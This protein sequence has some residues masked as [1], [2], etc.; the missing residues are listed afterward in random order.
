VFTLPPPPTVPTY[1]PVTTTPVIV[2]PLVTEQVDVVVDET[3]RLMNAVTLLQGFSHYLLTHS[4]TY[5]LTLTYSFTNLTTHS[6][7]H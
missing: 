7:I 6:L 5:S 3:Q 4:L 1:E 2:P